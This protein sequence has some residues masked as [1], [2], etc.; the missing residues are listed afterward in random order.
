MVT[1]G[2]SFQTGA[3]AV[4]PG[5]FYPPI[6]GLIPIHPDISVHKMPPREHRRYSN[7]AEEKERLA[8][9]ACPVCGRGRSEFPPGLDT[10]CCGPS[11]SAK[12]WRE[13]RPTVGEMRRLVLLEQE[14]KCAHCQKEIP[15]SRAAGSRH[16]LHPWI[17]DHILPIAMGGDQWAT[18][19]LQVLCSRCNKIK[20]ARD[21]GAIARWK[22]YHRRGL[23]RPEDRSWLVHEPGV[24]AGTGYERSGGS[25]LPFGVPRIGH[26]HLFHG[27]RPNGD[28]HK[29]V[30]TDRDADI[31][32]IMMAGA[33]DDILQEMQ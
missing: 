24:P 25:P 28:H 8:Q 32:V 1:A 23:A 19:N 16:L 4:C 29:R 26:E 15:A 12:Y 18:D 33:P 7:T 5:H 31:L 9:R 2:I 22:R 21:M 14:G 27:C 11:C 10:I 20:T 13:E 6:P 30:A 17:L 3:H